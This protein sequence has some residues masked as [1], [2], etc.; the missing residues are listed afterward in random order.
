M[1]A[2]KMKDDEEASQSD[3]SPR[4]PDGAVCRCV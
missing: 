1:Q 3:K 4:K 2:E